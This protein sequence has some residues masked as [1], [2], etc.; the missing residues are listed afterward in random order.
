MTF[1]NTIGGVVGFEEGNIQVYGIP[2]G[3]QYTIEDPGETSSLITV[4]IPQN[5]TSVVGY[6]LTTSSQIP[7]NIT[8][9]PSNNGV[10]VATSHDIQSS[11]VFFSI[12]QN[13]H[14]VLNAASIPVNSSQ[15]AL[16]S[17]PN[18]NKLNSTQS[19]ASLQVFPPNSDTPIASY[20]LTNG[21]QGL[22]KAPA[23][24][25]PIV[26]VYSAIAVIV[27]VLAAGVLVWR[28]RSE[29][30]WLDDRAQLHHP[31]EMMASVMTVLEQ[32]RRAEIARNVQR[33]H[34]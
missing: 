15:T 4:V 6:Q 13:S 14:S 20:T 5:Q 18:W 9:V 1:S 29:Y 19:A 31:G 3:I 11:L 33:H 27:I 26:L 7:L 28:R 23:A 34:A 22:P 30:H 24:G 12:G 32:P 25:L 8:I 16:Y 21:Q 17:V 2:M 10:R